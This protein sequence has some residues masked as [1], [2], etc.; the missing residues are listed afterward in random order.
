MP[1]LPVVRPTTSLAA[2]R[3]R[4]AASDISAVRRAFDIFAIVRARLFPSVSLWLR[5]GAPDMSSTHEAERHGERASGQVRCMVVDDHAAIREGVKMILAR[6]REISVIGECAS[7]DA[8]VTMAEQ[9]PARRR[10]DGRPHARHGRIRGHPPDH[11]HA[12]RHGGDP[13][14][15]ARASAACW[16]RGW[17]AARAATC[18]RTRRPTTSSAPSSEWPRAAPT[19]TPRSPRSWSRRRR[20]S[21]SR[22]CRRGSGRSSA[23]WP[24]GISNPEIAARLFISPETVRTH[25]R[26]AM[27]KLEA[28]TRTQAVALALR[29]ALID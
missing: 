6:D 29:Y 16:P 4:A 12:S 19:S 1:R 23:C 28:D 27:S 13:V 14:H 2:A 15:G 8:A 26:N 21:G 7:G 18:S 22:R 11:G 9:A 10:A 3:S 17:T 5:Q 25:V 20:P 24:T